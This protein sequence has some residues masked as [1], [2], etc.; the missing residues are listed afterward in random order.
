MAD[1]I[2]FIVT[3]LNSF[4][5]VEE[6]SNI[7]RLYEI[8]KGVDSLPNR[9]EALPAMFGLIERCC[10]EDLGAPGPLVHEIEAIRGYEES[11]IESLTRKPTLLTTWM[12]NRILNAALDVKGR[13]KWLSV[14]SNVTAHSLAPEDV[15][16][17]AYDFIE[18][19]L[20]T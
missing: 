16:S 1:D 2:H 5:P 3:E 4:E 14:L 18:R 7:Q 20:G 19:H 8:L 15:R 13:E 9:E 6:A 10:D 17:L 12:A 11:L